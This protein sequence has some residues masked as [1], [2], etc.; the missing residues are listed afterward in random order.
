[1]SI[2]DIVYSRKLGKEAI[3][4]QNE[5]IYTYLYKTARWNGK[6]YFVNLL[7]YFQWPVQNTETKA[8]PREQIEGAWKAKEW[9]R[10]HRRSL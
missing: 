8:A 9:C 2:E 1:M 5:I 7:I 4:E 3:K 6:H 10:K